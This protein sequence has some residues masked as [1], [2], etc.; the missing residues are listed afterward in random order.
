MTPDGLL[1]EGI[2]VLPY[3]ADNEYL[4]NILDTMIKPMKRPFVAM[5]I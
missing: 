4:A 2:T 1:G 3:K 5:G